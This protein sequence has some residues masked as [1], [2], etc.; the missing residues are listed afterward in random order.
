MTNAARLSQ[1]DDVAVYLEVGEDRVTL[2]VRDRGVGF[3]LDSVPTDRKGVSESIVGRMRR[4]GGVA[5]IHTAIGG[6]TEVELELP[7]SSAAAAAGEPAP[8]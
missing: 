5:T 3:D 2:Y 6:G 7:R 1:A 4:H 8:T